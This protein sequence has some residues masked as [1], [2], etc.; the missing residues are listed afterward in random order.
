VWCS[1]DADH[2]YL[3]PADQAD[4]VLADPASDKGEVLAGN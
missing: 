4:L 2:T 1:W 3:F